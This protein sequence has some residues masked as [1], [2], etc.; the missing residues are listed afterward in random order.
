MFKMSAMR[1]TLEADPVF[2][3]L[4]EWAAVALPLDLE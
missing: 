3:A 4:G 2:L 1:T